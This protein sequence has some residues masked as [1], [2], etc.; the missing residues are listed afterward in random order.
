MEFILDD[1]NVGRWYL[2]GSHSNRVY[3]NWSFPE[4]YSRDISCFYS[5][6][7]I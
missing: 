5:I 3:D 4:F 1:K 7:G 2:A 6:V